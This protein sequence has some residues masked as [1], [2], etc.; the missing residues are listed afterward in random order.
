MCT[1]QDAFTDGILT[2]GQTQLKYVLIGPD[3]D[4]NLIYI[5]GWIFAHTTEFSLKSSM[6]NLTKIDSD[7]A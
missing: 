6:S 1:V 3:F 7:I 4:K 2:Q 5:F